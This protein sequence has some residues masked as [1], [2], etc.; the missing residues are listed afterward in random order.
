MAFERIK[1]IKGHEYRYLVENYRITE[2][3]NK[4]KVRQRIVKSL[5]RVDKPTELTATP[6]PSGINIAD[7]FY[8]F[9]QEGCSAC[10]SESRVREYL[11]PYLHRACLQVDVNYIN[12]S[13]NNPTPIEICSTPTMIYIGKGRIHILRTIQDY[14]II[15]LGEKRFDTIY[16]EIQVEK[17]NKRTIELKQLV[18]S[19]MKYREL[20]NENYS[21]EE[22][23][24]AQGKP[25]KTKKEILKE[26]EKEQD[27]KNEMEEM[28]QRI[29]KINNEEAC[30]DGVCQVS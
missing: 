5:G 13:E 14:L 8:Y 11:E 2:G 27:M 10:S 16:D 28:K 7:G 4:G 3:I 22:I 24:I 19:G 21:K 26:Q 25:I 9:S 29:A 12:V 30:K 23:R 20:V 15:K 18:K 17:Q 6:T 1:K